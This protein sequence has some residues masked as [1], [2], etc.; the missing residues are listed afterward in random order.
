L[1]FA[2][3]FD[4]AFLMILFP[5]GANPALTNNMSLAKSAKGSEGATVQTPAPM[6][7]EVGV[8]AAACCLPLCLLICLPGLVDHIS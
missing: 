2:L 3:H 7:S 5:G 1:G 4:A 6:H 8:V